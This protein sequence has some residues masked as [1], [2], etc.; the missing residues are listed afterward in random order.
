MELGQGGRLRPERSLQVG[1]PVGEY[2]RVGARV[3]REAPVEVR[4]GERPVLEQQAEL[5][6]FE[7]VAV[8]LAEDREQDAVLETYRAALGLA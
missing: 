3:D 2:G 8:R 7:D 1:D 6:A 5:A 4:D